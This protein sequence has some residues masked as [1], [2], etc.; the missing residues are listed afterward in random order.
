VSAWA[1]VGCLVRL[2]SDFNDLAPNRD[3]ASDGSI[4]DTA[5]AAGGSSDHLPDEDFAALRG[6]DADSTNEVHAIDVDVDL[7]RAGVT[8]EKVVQHLL[9][10]CRDGRETRLRYIIFNRRIWSASTGWRQEAYT[11]ANPHDHHA[12]FSASYAT[13]RESDTRSWHLEEVIPVTAP[14]PEQN[15]AAVAARDV[16]P[17][18]GSQT[19]GGGVWT[20]LQRSDYLGNTWAPAQRKLLTDLNA[21]VEDQDDDLDALAASL[22]FLR[23]AATTL[24]AAADQPGQAWYDMMRRAVSDEL[25]ARNITGTSVE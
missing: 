25:D 16:D 6:K 21:R 8:M 13:A 10:R 17:G 3:R 5:H 4:G 1:L 11:G 23:E 20:L 2:R 24:T 19:L 15:A 18:P 22:T 9:D 7:R 12:H 14:T